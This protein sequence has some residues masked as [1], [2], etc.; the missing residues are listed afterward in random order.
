MRDRDIDTVALRDLQRARD[1]FIE[2]GILEAIVPWQVG[3]SWKR[4]RTM[5]VDPDCVDLPYICDPDTSSQLLYAADP[6]LR[7]LAA[8]LASQDVSV[9]LTHPDGLVV[10]RVVDNTKLARKLDE[11]RLAPGYSYTENFAGT[12]G[13]GTTVA[14]GEPT[15]IWGRQHYVGALGRLAC[16][17]SPIRDPI[18]GKVVG[19][20][21]LTCW[22]SHSNP[23]LLTLAKYASHQIEDRIESLASEHETA[24]M[25]VYRR[26]NRRYPGGVLAVGRDI[27]LM[28]PYLRR[29]L[30]MADQTALLTHVA[31]MLEATG[32]STTVVRLPSGNMVRISVAERVTRR[33]SASGA[34]FHA[35]I[36]SAA[37]GPLIS[38]PAF[39]SIPR[40]AGRSS[41]WQRSCQQVERCY[42]DRDWVVLEGESGSGRAT[43]ARAVAQH[44]TPERAVRVLRFADFDNTDVFI[45]ELESEMNSDDFVV[46]IGD[47][48]KLPDAALEALSGILTTCADNGWIAVTVSSDPHPPLVDML[49]LPFFPHTV[50]VPPLRH[51]IEDLE[52]LV[53]HLLRELSRGANVCLA[54]D[55]M[56]QLARL[57]WPGNIAQLRNVLAEILASHRSGT[58][59]LNQLPTECRSLARRKLTQLESLERDA[60]ICS[61]IENNGSKAAAAEALGISRATIYRKI[62]EFGIT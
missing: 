25:E 19:V 24:L 45:A 13:I 8:D 60:I 40:L 9:I 22:A 35:H 4:S 15:F 49:I 12:N 20:I 16:A 54:P 11:V 51:R 62:Q 10:E 57:A 6:V 34:V 56:R 30:D 55:A 28:N 59:G 58:I 31:E 18:S 36:Q 52:E 44:V 50:I 41:A 1:R 38:R 61:L 7:T 29:A 2:T 46:V 42:R 14:G 48:D 23:L 47:L 21:D 39:K 33:A 43:L 26:Q 37:E 3:A 27:V 5:Q 17:G 32:T 53:P